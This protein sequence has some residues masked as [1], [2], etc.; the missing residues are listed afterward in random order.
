MYL[1]FTHAISYQ[2]LA[3]LLLELFG[4]AI[5]EGALD[6]ALRRCKPRLDAD[7]AAILARLRR[8]RVVY[9]DETGVRIDGCGH[10]NWMFQNADVVIHVLRPS[11]AAAVVAEVLNGYWPV[12]RQLR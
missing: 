12:A 11:R 7:V 9:S 1:R 8:A 3:R 5:S 10:W 6:G 2:R 4:L